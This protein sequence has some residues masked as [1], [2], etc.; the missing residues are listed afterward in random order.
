MAIETR[1]RSPRTPHDSALEL[2][3]DEGRLLAG[4]QR[5]IDVSA[6]GL[7]FSTTRVFRKGAKI[8]GRIRIYER[9]AFE[10]EG[11][12]VRLKERSNSNLYG[13]AFDSIKGRLPP[14]RQ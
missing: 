4:A 2:L 3:D 14:P 1:R 11:R 13:V 8:R 10:F 9:G 5:L 7:S 6:L 12:V